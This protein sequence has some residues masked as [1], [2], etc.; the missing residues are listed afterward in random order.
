[1]PNIVRDIYC[2][3]ALIG[4]VS[5][6]SIRPDGDADAPAEPLPMA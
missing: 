3:L 1:M 4:F 6:A 5:R 2:D